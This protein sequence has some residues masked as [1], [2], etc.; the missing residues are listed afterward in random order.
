MIRFENAAKNRRAYRRLKQLYMEAFPPEERAPLLFLKLKARGRTCNMLSVY[1]GEQFVGL[2][3]AVTHSDLVYVFFLAVEAAQRGGG[4]GTAILAEV[5]RLYEGKRLM[6]CIE[7]PDE[8]CDN[9]PLRLR[10]KAFYQRCGYEEAGFKVCENGVMYEMLA[11]A[12]VTYADYQR[13]M[14]AFMGKTLFAIVHGRKK[15]EG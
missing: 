2:V 14:T 1:D 12:P 7:D 11:T 4:R 10:R 5:A 3:I 15:R 6:L 8:P 13:L 9:L